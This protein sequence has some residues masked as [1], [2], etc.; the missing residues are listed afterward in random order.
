MLLR[1]AS[2]LYQNIRFREQL[3]EL[4][5]RAEKEAI[6]DHLTNLAN[7]RSFTQQL[8]R[9]V[10][11]AR[12]HE[13]QF[14]LL[15]LDIDYFKVYN[16]TLGHQ[17]GDIALKKVASLLLQNTR[18]SDFVAR[19][20]G[21]EFSIICP[22]L[23]KDAGR[24][25]AEKLCTIVAQTPFPHEDKLPHRKVTVSIGVAAYPDDSNEIQELVKLADRALYQAKENGRNQV[26][27]YQGVV[28]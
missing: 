15:M 4:F 7:Y 26:Q 28:L 17:A 20:G 1:T 9:E 19:Y 16:D 3:K 2:L 25:L 10:N 24:Q 5:I 22:E 6:T 27:L 21:E 23:S 18:G 8:N 11:R 14:A 12:R 13:T